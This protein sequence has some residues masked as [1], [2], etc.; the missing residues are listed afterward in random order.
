VVTADKPV[1]YFDLASPYSY[2]AA[3]RI[4][5][6]LPVAP[7]WK[8]VWIGPIL[9][10]AGR[11]W[12]RPAKQVC[13]RHADIEQRATS[14]GMP[15]W[16]WPEKYSAAQELGVH[17]EPVNTLQV[18]RL[19]TLAERR[20]VG[21]EFA[22]R[23][24]HLAFGEGR[25]LTTFGEELIAVAVACGLDG[26][27]ACAAPGDPDIKQ[28]LRDVTEAASARGVAGLPT[29][30]VGE[31]LFWGDDRLEAAAGAAQP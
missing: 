9:A 11:D 19:A 5:G 25:D 31:E 30:A 13:E 8:P 26:D 7:V 22:R 1:F 29:V 18:M 21:E 12:R 3:F 10:A 2:L 27:E 14:Y 23:A 4:N 6:V 28:A 24:Y 16:R 20:G 17:A 15:P